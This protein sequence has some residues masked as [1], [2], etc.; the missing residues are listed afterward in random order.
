MC[1]L[2]FAL[3][4]ALMGAFFAGIV[5]KACF[6]RAVK[7]QA[8]SYAN[9]KAGELGRAAKK[10]QEGELMALISEAAMEFKAAKEHG[11]DLQQAAARII[12]QLMQKYPEAVMKHGKKLLKAVTDGGGLEALEDFIR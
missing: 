10:E 7:V 9:A 4:F 1:V 6:D 5:C 3:I 11:E 2:D 8:V 12:P